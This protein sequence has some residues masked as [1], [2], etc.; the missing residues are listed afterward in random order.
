ML[1]F[2]VLSKSFPHKKHDTETHRLYLFNLLQIVAY[3]EALK[4]SIISL[5]VRNLLQVDVEIRLESF[6][7]E[8]EDDEVQFTFEMG[9]NEAPNEMATKLDVMMNLMFT[10][11][12][13][14][15]NKGE[16]EK[17][18]TFALLLQIFDTFILKTHK[19]KYTQFLLFYICQM[20]PS[21]SE[22]FVVYLLNKM[23]DCSNH[24]L[25]RCTCAAY[26]AS[27]LARAKLV[28]ASLCIETVKVMATWCNKYLESHAQSLPDAEAHALFYSIAQAIFYVVC[29]KYKI[30]LQTEEARR[31][32]RQLYL[33]KIIWSR[34]NPFK[35]CLPTVVQEFMRINEVFALLSCAEIVEKNKKLVLPTKSLFGGDNQLDTFFPFDPYLL[36]Q[37]SKHI[38]D[39]YQTWAPI[40]EVNR[41]HE[42]QDLLPSASSPLPERAFRRPLSPLPHGSLGESP[43]SLVSV[44]P[45][46]SWRPTSM[47]EEAEDL[48]AT[49]LSL[50]PEASND[51]DLKFSWEASSSSWQT[52]VNS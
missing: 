25:T 35:F 8:D 29:F 41:G 39:L 4:A 44:T 18:E 5:A 2:D 40:D 30:L 33:D 10:F 37:S 11:V 7:D 14:F 16:K 52:V 47:N 23:L 49:Q 31:N 32:F 45:S 50:T 27:F 1:L 3:C 51:V 43:S 20:D 26:I 36:R 48:T 22:A 34:L 24:S 15:C 38:N 42:Q 12:D 6:V 19:S 9:E 28:P 46:S 17:K 21:F 13:S